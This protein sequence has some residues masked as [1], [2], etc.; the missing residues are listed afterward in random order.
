MIRAKKPT[1]DAIST[2]RF[3]V[4]SFFYRVYCFHATGHACVCFYFCEITVFTVLIVQKVECWCSLLSRGSGS[5]HQKS[6]CSLSAEQNA[7]LLQV[8]SGMSCHSHKMMS[9][10]KVE[11]S[12]WFLTCVSA[13]G[14][15]QIKALYYNTHGGWNLS[16]QNFDAG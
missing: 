14:V 12:C 11:D 1:S 8:C 5:R 9:L 4:I 3:V 7:N 10:A 2:Q 13:G 6:I 15:F 16:R